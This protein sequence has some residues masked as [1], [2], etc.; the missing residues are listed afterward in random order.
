VNEEAALIEQPDGSPGA[1]ADAGTSL[2][3]VSGGFERAGGVVARA[4]TTVS[5][6]EGRA[7]VSFDG[8]V[9]SYGLVMVAVE[10]ALSAAR[11][12]VRKYETALED[13]KAKIRRLRE[14][15]DM[16]VAR[17][18]RAKRQ[19]ED[20]QGRLGEAQGRMMG[21]PSLTAG[22]GEP[23]AMAAQVQAQNDADDAQG[24]IDAAQKQIDRERE[25]IG[26]LREDARRVREQLIE[27][28]Q[29]AA[30]AVRAAA[31]QLPDVQL[32]GGAASP[33]AYSGT[34]F[35]GPVSPF[36][37]D[38]RWASAMAKA[39]REE[40]PEKSFLDRA[41]AT[42]GRG[43]PLDAPLTIADAISP[44]FRE[45]FGRE[46]VVNAPQGLYQTGKMGVQLTVGYS[47]IDPAGSERAA[48]Q[49]Q[50]IVDSARQDPWGFTKDASGITA[51]EEGRPGSFTA[52]WALAAGTAGAGAGIKAL[53]IPGK[54]IPDGH[55]VPNGDLLPLDQRADL[56]SPAGARATMEELTAAANRDLGDNISSA[57]E[58]GLLTQDE[59]A[60]GER[61]S[62][63]APMFYGTAVERHV[64]A[65][66]EHSPVLSQSLVHLG[67]P[68]EAD[69]TITMP[70]GTRVEFD[71]TTDNPR[72]QAQHRARPYGP[73]LELIGYRRPDS[74]VPFPPSP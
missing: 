36:A 35:A 19:L 31:G 70:D 16:A 26:E 41:L 72:T 65:A 25:E 43:T 7:S 73:G 20:A 21:T 34:I 51:L 39:A 23:G 58:R 60:A 32:P 10:Q 42:F 33:S 30:S 38:P 74:V 66:I 12:A 59:Y 18:Q 61:R 49:L 45:D 4:S 53:T 57:V 13:A 37:R 24:E 50:G 64:A 47:L 68:N 17:L 62:Y 29:D 27:D 52:Q 56:G 28:E 22:L 71:V 40:K 11:G 5:G 63:L 48:R 15:E 6:W 46:I 14:Q 55:V 3:R 44:G 8:R 69:F 9:A 1:V 54:V 67:G 2:Q